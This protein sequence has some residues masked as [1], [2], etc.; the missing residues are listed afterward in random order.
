M[1]YRQKQTGTKKKNAPSTKFTRYPGAKTGTIRSTNSGSKKKFNRVYSRRMQNGI[2][3]VTSYCTYQPNKAVASFTYPSEKEIR[4]DKHLAQKLNIADV[5][6]MRC[7]TG[8]N[9]AKPTFPGSDYTHQQIVHVAKLDG[10]PEEEATAENSEQFGKDITQ[11]FN[12]NGTSSKYHYPSTRFHYPTRFQYCGDITPD[13]EDLPPAAKYFLDSDVVNLIKYIYPTTPLQDIAQDGETV[14]SFFG[15]DRIDQ[16]R[17]L[18]L[19]ES[20]SGDSGDE[21]NYGND[22]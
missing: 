21:C 8:I 9:V 14:A 15:D 1:P 11:F 16:G 3:T 5:L 19:A 20:S 13:G 17:A 12:K 6:P 18:L 4:E 22:E 7:S 2:T 10:T